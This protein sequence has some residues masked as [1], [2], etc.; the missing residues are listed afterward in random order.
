MTVDMKMSPSGDNIWLF[1]EI[2]N[3]I[4]QNPWSGRS[5]V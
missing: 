2:S 4:K 5:A 3:F 1:V